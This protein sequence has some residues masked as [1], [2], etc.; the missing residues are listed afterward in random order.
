VGDQ[1]VPN[2]KYL[3]T[4]HGQ[5]TIEDMRAAAA[6]YL[7]QD[8]RAK[9]AACQ[10]LT[11][12]TNSLDKSI[13][14][15]LMLRKAEYTVL[16]EQD[17]PTMLKVLI[18]TVCI[19]TRATVSC[20]RT[21]LMVLPDK[22]QEF[23]S[24]ITKFNQYVTELVE[25]LTARGETEDNLL[26]NLFMTYKKTGNPQFVVYIEGKEND[27][28]DNTTPDLK[29]E[30]LMAQAE[31]KYK[32]MVQKKEWSTVDKQS[33]HILALAASF[34]AGRLQG[35]SKKGGQANQSQKTSGKSQKTRNPGKWAWKE[36]APTGKESW[37]KTFEN[38]DYIHCP[39][40]N[41]TKWVLAENHKDGCTLA[42]TVPGKQ[43]GSAKVPSKKELQYAKALMAVM[44]QGDEE[45][46]DDEDE[47]V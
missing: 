13:A 23:E 19:E 5:V 33:E 18:A 45:E 35:E 7:V 36:I 26:N 40:H 41:K 14:R 22:L 12:L 11:L 25:G 43:G 4:Q 6:V 29:P 20:I 9:Q 39:N 1:T 10:L 16:G 38:K 21:A 24:D 44:E 8:C 15:K 3:L 46:A 42:P 34:E 17:G 28:E 2:V 32:T 30:T 37:E 47:N 31:A 27:W